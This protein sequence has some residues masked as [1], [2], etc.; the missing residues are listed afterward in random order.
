MQINVKYIGHS[1]FSIALEN[2]YLLFDYFHGEFPGAEL[3]GFKYA[4]VFSSHSH[5]DHFNKKIFT[6]SGKNPGARFFLSDDIKAVNESAVYM[7]PGDI[8]RKADIEV[9]SFGSTDLG[10]SFAIMCEGITIF[11]AGDLNLWSW[12]KESTKDEIDEASDMFDKEIK[13]IAAQFEDFD[14]AFFPVDPRMQVDYGEGAEIFLAKFN[15]THF[16]PMHF[17][18][19]YKAAKDFQKKYEGDTIIHAPDSAGQIFQIDI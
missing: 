6:L 2:H 4:D 8:C 15:V 12:K 7:K 13:K 19:R 10:V 9:F 11:H 5:S 18:V 17:G 16:F 3:S 1:G 14:I